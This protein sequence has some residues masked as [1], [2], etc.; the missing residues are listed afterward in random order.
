[1]SGRTHVVITGVAVVGPGSSEEAT[2]TTRVTFRRLTDQEIADYVATGEPMD[3]AGGYAIQGGAKGFVEK[4]DG[5]WSNVV[6]LPLEILKAMLE[7]WCLL[8]STPPKHSN[9]TL[10]PLKEGRGG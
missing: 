10:P 7:K 6:G 1:L 5:S 9:V 2:D 4:I 3:K 8:R